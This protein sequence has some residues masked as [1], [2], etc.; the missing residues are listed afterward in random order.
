MSKKKNPP[1]RPT[2]YKK[3]FCD[4][5]ERLTK[6][7]LIDKELADFFKISE[8]TLN[9]WKITY[10][11]FL[12][13]IKRGKLIADVN[14]VEKLYERACGSEHDDLHIAVIGQKIVKTKIVKK[15]PPET[16]ACIF[17][18]KNR[19]PEKWRD[20]QAVAHEGAVA[21]ASM[22]ASPEIES[23]ALANIARVQQKYQ[24]KGETK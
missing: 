6:L 23:V 12:E 17:W 16:V 20:V 24:P 7:G 9:S 22:K 8:S 19:Q 2:L 11:D 5:A 3:A 13:S 14:V 21:V 18:L 10:P 1:H 15:Y 4:Q